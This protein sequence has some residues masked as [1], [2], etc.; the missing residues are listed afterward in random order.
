MHVVY[1]A[2]LLGGALA[3]AVFTLLGAGGRGGAHHPSA[4]HGLHLPHAH[5]TGHTGTVSPAHPA[6]IGRGV[7]LRSSGWGKTVAGWT[8][9]W[10]SPLTLAAAALWFGALGLLT[11]GPFG[12]AALA[13]AIAGAG[14][15]AFTIRCVMG[16]LVRA[17]TPP[18]ALGADGALA[19]V[20]ATIRPEATGEVI[21]TLE[22]LTRSMPARCLDG[23]I[24]HRGTS[25]AIVRQEKGVA[26]VAPLG[27]DPLDARLPTNSSNEEHPQVDRLSPVAETTQEYR[28]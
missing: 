25:V 27:T 26:W 15:G 11:E 28:I 7:A 14:V 1:L 16:A 19:T 13:P 12:A 18:L 2:C 17:G 24:L 4:G 6:K 3:T 21:Y 23:G 5:G 9:S 8:L 10:F 20:N 22:G